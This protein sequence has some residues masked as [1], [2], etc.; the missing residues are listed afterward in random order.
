MSYRRLPSKKQQRELDAKMHQTLRS[1]MF[2]HYEREESARRSA[3]LEA[4]R[5]LAGTQNQ[6]AV[7][8]SE[9]MSEEDDLDLECD[10]ELEPRV[11]PM[12]A[13]PLPPP[14]PSQ[15]ETPPVKRKEPRTRSRRAV[16]A[17]APSSSAVEDRSA[18]ENHNEPEPNGELPGGGDEYTTEYLDEDESLFENE[19]TAEQKLQLSGDTAAVEDRVTDHYPEVALDVDTEVTLDGLKTLS[20]EDVCIRMAY[21]AHAATSGGDSKH[22]GSWYMGMM[23]TCLEAVATHEYARPHLPFEV[24]RLLDEYCDSLSESFRA[25][26]ERNLRKLERR[27]LLP[28][29]LLSS[30][31]LDFVSTN[32]V[33]VA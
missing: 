20:L 3:L 4:Q 27:D 32:S 30:C 18:R 5:I 12:E 26:E 19:L 1:L 11:E 21:C 2:P 24:E 16:H 23:K 15:P 31:V 9:P 10:L 33:G 7:L 29:A 13:E 17:A 6:P 8:K 28:K 25:E 14:P 22:S